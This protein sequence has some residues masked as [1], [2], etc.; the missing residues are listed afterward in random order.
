MRRFKIHHE[1]RERHSRAVLSLF[2]ILAAVFI[3]ASSHVAQNTQIT[4]KATDSSQMQDKELLDVAMES[5]YARQL[6]KSN[7]YKSDITALDNGKLA[8]SDLYE[9]VPAGSYEVRL[10]SHYGAVSVIIYKGE[11]FRTILR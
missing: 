6:M 9:G 5:A 7:D 8:E 3:T 4:A 1:R 11:L 10:Y 2:V